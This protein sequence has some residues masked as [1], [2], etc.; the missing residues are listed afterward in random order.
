MATKL[1]LKIMKYPIFFPAFILWLSA[2]TVLIAQSGITPGILIR[3]ESNEAC[4]E[5]A[6]P[7]TTQYPYIYLAVKGGDGGVVQHTSGGSGALATGF[8]AIGNAAGEIRP[9][10]TLRLIPGK[11]GRS[12][13]QV[14]DGPKSG[15]GGG[16]GSAIL[17]LGPNE[18]DWHTSKI[19][20][21]AGGGGGGGQPHTGLS[22]NIG[23]AGLSGTSS[24]GGSL[25]NQGTVGGPGKGTGYGDGGASASTL[26]Y[27]SFNEGCKPRSAAEPGY[28]SGGKGSDS[29]CESMHGGWGFG[30]GGAGYKAGGGGGGYS[31]GSGGTSNSDHSGGGGG[32]G[33]YIN[34]AY[35][36]VNAKIIAE[37]PLTVPQNGYVLYGLLN[38]YSAVH[39]ATNQAKCFDTGSNPVNGSNVQLFACND[40]TT[41]KWVI[42]GS[43]LRLAKDLGKCL[44]LSGGNTANGT[45]IRLGDC[46]TGNKNQDWFYD[47]AFKYIR[48]GVDFNKCIDLNAG[49]TADNTNIQL[50]DCGTPNRQKWIVDGISPNMCLGDH[51]NIQMAF[52]PNKCVDISGSGTA[53]D[54]NIQLW[55]CNGSNAQRFLFNGRAI[56][57]QSALNKC[58]DLR[59]SGTANGTNIQLYDCNT[60]AAQQ[61]IYDAFDKAFHS[62][63]DFNKCL[64]LDHRK[65]DNGTNIRLWDCNGT[66]AQQFVISQ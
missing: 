15:A 17:I 53:N 6:I 34:P 65:L 66:L 31:G 19:L 46:Q 14:G 26:A 63:V 36:A 40:A 18:T 23:A 8:F 47:V 32:G 52:A 24:S 21:V 48:S 28:P 5:I 50:W 9:G 30:G 27:C 45:N 43:N 10:S 61:W 39:L 16:G 2:Q 35:S 37:G 57:M 44:E 29:A 42:D 20:L 60:S 4:T 33:S 51:K 62:A 55:D 25:N 13:G 59:Q 54:T 7:N 49:N 64:D 41:Q 38:P 58:I 11:M 1:K 22:A 56:V 3:Y 12:I